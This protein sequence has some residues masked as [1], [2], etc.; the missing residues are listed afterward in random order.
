MT[1]DL[2]S[3]PLLIADDNG[4]PL[5]HYKEGQHLPP[6]TLGLSSFQIGDSL[7][8]QYKNVCIYPNPLSYDIL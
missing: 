1:S 7:L 6:I 8:A 3:T 5:A 2:P 4:Q